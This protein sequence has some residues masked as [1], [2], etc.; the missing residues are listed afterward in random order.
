M[1]PRI[2]VHRPSRC[3]NA[4]SP[5]RL[6]HSCFAAN[7]RANWELAGLRAVRPAQKQF[8]ECNRTDGERSISTKILTL[9]HLCRET[10]D[11]RRLLR[12]FTVTLALETFRQVIAASIHPGRFLALQSSSAR[13][14]ELLLSRHC[15]VGSTR[16]HRPGLTSPWPRFSLLIRLVR[17]VR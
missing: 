9:L 13:S 8:I 14:A 6:L 10:R 1:G 2:I 17:L 4:T 16:L 5:S 12:P 3:I 11:G 7:E 15:I